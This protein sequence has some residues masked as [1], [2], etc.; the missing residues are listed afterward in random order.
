MNNTESLRTLDVNEYDLNMRDLS[1]D[2]ASELSTEDI[3][4]IE[5]IEEEEEIIHKDSNAELNQEQFEDTFTKLMEDRHAEDTATIQGAMDSNNDDKPAA[6]AASTG[7]AAAAAA[8]M[9][10]PGVPQQPIEPPPVEEVPTTFPPTEELDNSGGNTGG[11][12]A[13][14]EG[15]GEGEEEED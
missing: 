5:D 4:D 7:G 12:D 10:F 11:S 2:I 14:G 3:E 6:A 13:K 9:P 8:S 1:T 15:G